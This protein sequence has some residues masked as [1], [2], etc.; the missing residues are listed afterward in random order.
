[1]RARRRLSA[2]AFRL[3]RATVATDGRH[4][5]AHT[6]GVQAGKLVKG[7]D[8]GRRRRTQWVDTQPVAPRPGATQRSDLDDRVGRDCNDVIT[9]LA[10]VSMALGRA[11]YIANPSPKRPREKGNRGQRPNWRRSFPPSPDT[12]VVR[13]RQPPPRIDVK[14]E[15]LHPH[16]ARSGCAEFDAM[17]ERALRHV[18][19]GEVVPVTSG[20]HAIRT[21][22]IEKHVAVPGV[23][24]VHVSPRGRC[25]TSPERPTVWCRSRSHTPQPPPRVGCNR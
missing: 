15:G 2:S 16:N 13:L 1:M 4:G 9:Q 18:G 19:I 7:S 11:G 20:P 10:A 17:V 22:R 14:V 24:H 8:H 25:S 21:L 12:P 5:C 3:S 23:E 6:P